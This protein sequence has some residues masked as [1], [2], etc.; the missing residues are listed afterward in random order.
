MKQLN[1]LRAPFYFSLS[2]FEEIKYKHG[3]CFDAILVITKLKLMVGGE[4]LFN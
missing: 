4:T 1:I 3:V 2:D